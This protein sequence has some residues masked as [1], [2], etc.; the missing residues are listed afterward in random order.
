LPLGSRARGGSIDSQIDKYKADEAAAKK[1]KAKDDAAATKTA[2]TEAREYERYISIMVDK[3]AAKQGAN[4][5]KREAT[6][7]LDSMMKWQPEKFVML[8]K[9]FKSENG[10]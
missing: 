5:N 8:M 7:T 4:F 1:Q 9:K 10:L 3:V 6:A 2:K